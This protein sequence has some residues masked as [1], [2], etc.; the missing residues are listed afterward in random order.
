MWLSQVLLIV[1]ILK[2]GF[3]RSYTDIKICENIY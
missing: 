1:R 3:S 2:Q